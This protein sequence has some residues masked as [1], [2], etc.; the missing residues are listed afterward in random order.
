MTQYIVLVKE[1]FPWN[2]IAALP[3]N[4]SLARGLKKASYARYG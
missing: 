2:G 3:S 4:I 1:I